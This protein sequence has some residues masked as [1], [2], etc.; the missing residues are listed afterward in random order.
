M[1]V[2]AKNAI[3]LVMKHTLQL[4]YIIIKPAKLHSIF[5][6]KVQ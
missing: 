2:T 3:L 4:S 6:Y 5:K 1:K